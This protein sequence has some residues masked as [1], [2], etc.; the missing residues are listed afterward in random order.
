METV[1]IQ[2]LLFKIALLGAIKFYLPSEPDSGIV[3]AWSSFKVINQHWFS[4]LVIMAF[5]CRT[6]LLSELGVK[7]TP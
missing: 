2:S 5:N 1:T 3:I 4:F 7:V 6:E